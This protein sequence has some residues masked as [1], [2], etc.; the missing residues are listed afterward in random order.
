M[1]PITDFAAYVARTNKKFE[2]ASPAEK[3]VI[4]AQDAIARLSADNL[5]AKFGKVVD[6]IPFALPN[7]SLKDY[8]NSSHNCKVCAKGALFCSLVGRVNKVTIGEI[9]DT[10][11]NLLSDST[12]HKLLEY[13]SAE[14]LDLVETAFEGKT[15]LNA[16]DSEQIDAAEDFCD[17]YEWNE[18][19][20]RITAICKNIITNKGEFK[21]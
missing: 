10:D 16:A 6:Y 9:N 21:P 18:T 2:A 19:N 12:H 17:E 7:D 11:T 20:E 4:I 14:Q 5:T 3:R 13:F 1:K 15:Y 8:V